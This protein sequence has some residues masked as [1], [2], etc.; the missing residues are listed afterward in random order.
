MTINTNYPVAPATFRASATPA[1]ATPETSSQP[2]DGWDPGSGLIDS[3][4]QAAQMPI[5]DPA[6]QTALGIGISAAMMGGAF[7]A[8]PSISLH[9][10]STAEGGHDFLYSYHLQVDEAKGELHLRGG[11]Y[12][13]MNFF[14][15]DN[16]SMT[17]SGG[18]WTGRFGAT[19][20][21]LAISF[22]ESA[23][24][25]RARGQIGEVATDVSFSDWTE[26]GFQLG[27]SLG[28]KS[29]SVATAFEG[30]DEASARIVARGA[31]EGAGAVD[32]SYGL[33]LSESEDAMTLVLQG[34][35]KNAGLD[36]QVKV[37]LNIGQ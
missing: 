7:G 3:P 12:V 32:K 30:E 28:G 9:F 13:D 2:V 19:D 29:Y 15:M 24:A 11:G 1:A 16:G 26:Q 20:T 14:A 18:A 23:G 37:T 4:A 36:Q 5:M 6:F 31:L 8:V 17:E 22:D 25:V 10:E 34:G 21:D 35:G 33:S 27:G